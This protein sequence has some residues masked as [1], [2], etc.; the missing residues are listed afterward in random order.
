[1]S[2]PERQRS[3]VQTRGPAL[4]AARQLGDLRF[5]KLDAGCSQQRGRLA[6]AQ[7]HL[8]GA[9]LDQPSLCPEACDR[10][11][12]VCTT[13]EC[14]LR[15]LGQVPDERGHGRY[16]LRVRE[17]VNVVEHEDDRLVER[18]ERSTQPCG[19]FAGGR[20]RRGKGLEDRGIHG[21]NPIERNGKVGE[22]GDGLVVGLV[23]RNPRERAVS[24]SSPLSEERRLAV[25]E[26]RRQDRHPGGTRDAEAIDERGP[27]NRPLSRRR[28]AELRLHDD[29]AR[30][31]RGAQP[32]RRD[33]HYR[34]RRRMLG[35]PVL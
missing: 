3:Q 12:D 18:R 15:L 31:L 26:R 20:S 6:R 10:Q 28:R 17:Q 21:R 7:P 11:R 9:D 14:D 25:A 34:T 19:D 24:S 35:A 5:R 22:E 8:V 16:A 1:M 2:R 13:R 30:R 27:A 23:E 32:G 33:A 29:E 4:G